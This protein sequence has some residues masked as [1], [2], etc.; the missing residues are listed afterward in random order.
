MVESAFGPRLGPRTFVD[1]SKQ[2]TVD[3][4][5]ENDMMEEGIDVMVHPGDDDEKHIQVHMAMMQAGDPHG[6]YM[7]HIALHQHQIQAKN[8]AQAQ[9][10][11]GGQPG[12]APGGPQPGSQAGPQVTKAPPGAMHQDRMAGAGAVTM[13]RKT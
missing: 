12:G 11:Q 10:M 13:P 5:V 6:A 4:L 2:M 9:K 8:M 3:P 1:L 7:R